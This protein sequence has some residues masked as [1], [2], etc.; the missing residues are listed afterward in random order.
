MLTRES[1]G[2]IKSVF[3][4]FVFCFLKMRVKIMKGAYRESGGDEMRSRTQWNN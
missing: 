3:F 2:L 1:M 4:G